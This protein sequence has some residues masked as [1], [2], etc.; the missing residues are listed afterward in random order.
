MGEQGWRSGESAC[1][2]PGYPV[3]ESR[4]W[5]HMWGEFVVGF[6]SRSERFFSRYSGFPLPS[7]TNISKFQFDLK[8]YQALY[9]EPLAW[10]I[11]QALL[12]FDIKCTFNSYIFN[13]FNFKGLFISIDVATAMAHTCTPAKIY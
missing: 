8:Y 4:T 11:V 6:L 9:H 3:F 13:K 12:V 1:I 7:K 10:V 2:P 5:L